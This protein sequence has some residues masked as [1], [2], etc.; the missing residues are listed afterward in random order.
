ME[1]LSWNNDKVEKGKIYLSSAQKCYLMSRNTALGF[2]DRAIEC[3]FPL[4]TSSL[5]KPQYYN[6]LINNIL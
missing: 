5:K 1:T 6:L 4:L 2:I 3:F